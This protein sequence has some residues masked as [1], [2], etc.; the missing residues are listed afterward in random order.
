MAQLDVTASPSRVREL[1][2]GRIPLKHMDVG[3]LIAVLGLAVLGCMMVFSATHHYA[4]VFFGLSSTYYLKRQVLFVVL[5]IAAM[6]LFAAVDYRL[7]KAWA[8]V[9][10]AAI[11]LLLVAVRTPLGT[12]ALGSQRWFQ[13]AGFQFSP[14]LFSRLVL[15]A[16]MAAF[17]SEIRGEIDARRLVRALV[18]A[19]IPMAL[20]FIQP[21]IGT[22]IILTT[23]AVTE[24][25]VAGT[26][27]RY[28]VVL[29]LVATVAI[30]GAFQLHII[31]QYQ[32]QRLTGF[33]DQSANTQAANY[34][35]LQSK[36]AIGSGGLWGAGYL[37]GT[38]TNL[39]FVPEQYTD[40][41]FT[42]VGEELGFV[43]AVGL[44]ALY[45]LLLWR[46]Y[47]IALL[48]KDPFGTFLATG[49]GAMVMIQ[50]FVNIGMT[51]GIMPIT[52]IPLPFLSYG[53]SALIADFSAMGI[54]Q[55][56]R[57]RSMR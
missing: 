15:A 50:M 49:I 21:D 35:L 6:V 37:H 32:L 29:T 19:G 45:A 39:A 34:N 27:A 22:T 2:G 16:M 43:G 25:V 40:F 55:S 46:T 28:L 54:L 30:V 52:G 56:I 18:I 41:V 42:V 8:P 36:I 4:T 17:L 7:L 3:L 10:Y 9:A 38:Q 14:S 33:M 12:S 48:A 5:G 53:G 24:L 13:V 44:L 31:K 23:I 51:I 47:R 20:V 57:M 26:R 1:L 11:V